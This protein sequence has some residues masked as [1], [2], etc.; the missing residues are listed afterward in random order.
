MSSIV[1]ADNDDRCGL[2]LD[3]LC[4]SHTYYAPP[5]GHVFCYVCIDQYKD[6]NICTRCNQEFEVA[7]PVKVLIR[8]HVTDVDIPETP[9]TSVAT[10]IAIE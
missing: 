5:C 8:G 1:Y 10:A 6:L 4:D 7:G 3:D 2:C 9:G